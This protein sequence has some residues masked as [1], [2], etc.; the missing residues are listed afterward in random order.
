MAVALHFL[1][2]QAGLAL[3]VGPLV[4]AHVSDVVRD[5]REVGGGVAR[6]SGRHIGKVSILHPQRVFLVLSEC[7]VLQLLANA[8]HFRI[9]LGIRLP[10]H[11]QHDLAVILACGELV[12]C[13]LGVILR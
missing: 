9:P 12:G 6:V 3:G 2:K 7:R 4:D 8:F 13:V 11:R 1:Q 10:A 5:V